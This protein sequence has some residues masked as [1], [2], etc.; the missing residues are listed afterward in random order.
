[1]AT[2]DVAFDWLMQSEDP[3]G[4]FEITPDAPPGAHAIGGINSYSFP[5]AFRRIVALP[6]ASRKV[7]VYGF[8]RDYFWN[9]GWYSQLESDE[10]AKRVF[11]AAVNMGSVT[12]VKILQ[13][14]MEIKDDGLWGP[15]TIETA[16]SRDIGSLLVSLRAYRDREY[17]AIV[18]ARPEDVKYLKGWLDRCAR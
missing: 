13:R 11:D 17:D 12:A 9:P 15:E 14:A 16:N 10:L 3:S 7:G 8:Y 6:R 5:T 4:T 18:K 2:F 1:M